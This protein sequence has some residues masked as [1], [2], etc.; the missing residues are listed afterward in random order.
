[1]LTTG[2]A[3]GVLTLGILSLRSGWFEPVLAGSPAWVRKLGA[4]DGD[5]PYGGGHRGRRPGDALLGALALA[6]GRLGP[7]RRRPRVSL[8]RRAVPLSERAFSRLLTM[9]ARVCDAARR[10]VRRIA[11]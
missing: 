7:E 5:L 9:A 11:A 6:I 2:L 1:M 3:G 10:V 8:S 4:K